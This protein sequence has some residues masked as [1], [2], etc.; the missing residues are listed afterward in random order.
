M[1]L[2]AIGGP[3][4]VGKTSLA[5]RMSTT[6]G[7]PHVDF[8]RISIDVVTSAQSE[9][10]HLTEDQLLA[11][12]RDDRYTALA[13][14]ISDEFMRPDTPAIVIATAPFTQQSQRLDLWTRW[15]H[16]CGPLTRADMVWLDLDPETRRQRMAHRGASRDSALLESGRSLPGSPL[17]QIPHYRLDA[18]A[19]LNQQLTHL[20]ELFR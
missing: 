12:V 3:A 7:L 18:A 11:L 4:G 10:P 2:V 19:P 13:Q 6:L 20:A 8:D 16:D 17:P 14:A 1:H 15:L 5:D 9:H